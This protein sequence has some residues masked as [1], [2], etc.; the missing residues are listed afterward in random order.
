VFREWID[1]NYLSGELFS[2][3][4]LDVGT[5]ERLNRAEELID[6]L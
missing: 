3:D 6:N 1:R 5:I 2:G 4:W